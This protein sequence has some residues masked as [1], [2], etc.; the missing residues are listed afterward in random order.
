MIL[1]DGKPLGVEGESRVQTDPKRTFTA[2]SPNTGLRQ[3][4]PLSV[5]GL[6]W[7]GAENGHDQ[8]YRTLKK[9]RL[10][11]HFVVNRDG[12]IWQMTDLSLYCAHIGSRHDR[13][14][15]L[16]KRSI[17]IEIVSRGFATKAD[18]K[19]SDLRDRSEYDWGVSRDVYPSTIDG[20][21]ART[22]AFTQEQTWSVLWLVETLCGTCDV[23]RRIPMV[24]LGDGVVPAS[25]A[26]DV[27]LVRDEDGV[28]WVPA[29][30][31]DTR[32]RSGRRS[33]FDGVL[34]HFHVHDS[35]YDPGSHLFYELWRE[36]FN[37]AGLKMPRSMT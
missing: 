12:S 34:G 14:H 1:M 28:A 31:R 37:P 11:I 5:I 8:V 15:S 25:I 10:S 29:F 27:D 35:K 17:G 6:H 4:V 2:K 7:T 21:R 36:G 20:H 18:L 26:K 33:T 30:D 13:P 22:V 16:N 3:H 24:K 23:P 9:R 32:H 19:G